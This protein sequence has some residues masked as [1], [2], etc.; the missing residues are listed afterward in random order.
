[1]PFANKYVKYIITVL[2]YFQA[3]KKN[4][5][6]AVSWREPNLNLSSPAS[7]MN[8]SFQLC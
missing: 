4:L 2:H 5:F 8:S 7:Q 3:S 6:G 1:M